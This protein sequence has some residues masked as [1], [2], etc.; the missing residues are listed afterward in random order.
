L[1][2]KVET[3]F[4]T[5]KDRGYHTAL[6]GKQHTTPAEAYP[7]TFDPKVSGRDVTRIA[8][9]AEQFIQRAGDEPF[10]LTIGYSDPHPTSIERPGWGVKRNDPDV[11]LVEY[12]PEEVI[13]PGYLP[14]RP[15]VRE[16]L[17][18]YY[19]QISRLD[20]G[21]GLILDLL[22][23]SG[24][25]DDTLVLFTSDHGSSEPGAMANHYEPGIRVPFIL[26]NPLSDAAGTT[27]AAM[28]TLADITP[29]IL[30]W[31][32]VEPGVKLHGR[33]VL[34][35][36]DGSAE[37]GWDEVMLSHVCH[38]VTMY[39]PMR[40]IRDRRY[41]LIWNIDHRS[42][43]P[44][45]IDTLRRATWT[46]A[47]RRGEPTIGPRSIKQF[48]FRDEIELYDL[49]DDPDEVINRADDPAF[50]EVR[51]RLSS[52]LIDWL[53]ETGDPWLFRHRLPLPGEPEFASTRQADLDTESGYRPLFNGKNLDGWTLRR[54][55]R[56]G[57]LVKNGLLVCP[58]DGGGYLFTEQQYSDFS[59]RFEFRLSEAANN[60]IAI[61][62]PLVDARPAYQGMEF[63][64]LDHRGYPK[65]LKPE[66]YHGSLYGVAAAKRG[67]LKPVGHW[68]EQ[69]IWCRGRR[70][71]VTLNDIVILDVDLDEVSDP[72]T[73]ET[74]PGVQRSSGHI[75]LL[76]HGSRVE[77]RN[78]RVK[79]LGRR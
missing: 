9:L 30:D 73:R 56:G 44:L 54:A 2:P 52:R 66:Q 72:E 46:E 24:K 10:F 60:G 40:T 75:G 53:E 79:E 3:V 55:D 58:A 47:V 67:A 15:E 34:P 45:P 31:V 5:L 62:S 14:D 68:N 43:Y 22:K 17:A 71:V 23:Q 26:R 33:S 65:K 29:T 37:D 76:G 48:L 11:P 57:Y 35:V 50:R 6:L 59:F 28:V 13:V 51:E 12:R 36:S 16:G 20:H 32:G 4:A 63:Q 7:F 70:V 21:I 69:E 49:R 8:E 78:L 77:F 1:A 27:S 74:H 18:G 38:E 42:E 39:Y 25:D 19:Q 64:I 61:R 41:K